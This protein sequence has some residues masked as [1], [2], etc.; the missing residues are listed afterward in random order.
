[1][2][3]TLSEVLPAS[4]VVT[5]PVELITYEVDAGLDRGAP[6][7]VVF[8]QAEQDVVRVARWATEHNVALIARG[9]GTG[10][11]GGAI[12][13]RGGVIVEF[14][15]MNRL[16]ELDVNGRS[17]VVEP[18]ILNL[19]VDDI[20]KKQGLYYP[21]DPAS[22]R[23][24]TIGG[25]VA[26]N[27]GGPHCFKYGVTTNYVTG[28]RAVLPG[29]RVVRVGG[30]A[31]DYP[32]YD[33]VGAIV[34][35]EGTLALITSIDV[36]LVQNPPGVK[37][38]MAVFDS[39]EQ[40]GQAVSAVIAAGLVPATMEMMDHH[41]AR[42]IEEYAHPGLPMDA[43]AILIIETDGYPASL[44]TQIEE[45]ADIL[46]A[47]GGRGIRIAQS[48]EERERIWFARK[49]AAGA[50]SRFA[51]AYYLVDI[52]VPRSRLAETLAEVN[53]ICERYHVHAGHV[54][55]AGDGN[56][57]PLIAIMHPEDPQQVQD[58]QNAG[59]EMVKVGVSKDGSLTGEHG[60]GTEKRQYMPMM[61]SGAELA[62]MWDI[63]Q[64]FDPRG[65]FNPGKV[66][67]SQ[68]PPVVQARNDMAV[69]RDPFTP[70]SAE[71]AAEGLAAL[72]KAGR[73]VRIGNVDNRDDHAEI[74]L[75]TSA[76]T[77]IKAYAPDD[78]YVTVGAGTLL[79]E[80]QTFLARD[81]KQIPIAS[82]RKDATIGGIVASNSN[83]PL[84]MR[85]GGI[86]D[87]VLAMTV[88]LGDGR[89]IRA[90]R[91]VVKNVAGYDMPKVFIGSYGTLGLLTDVTLKLIPQ[92]RAR[93]TLLVPVDDL[94]QGMKWAGQLLP[95]ALV[96]SGI[97]VAKSMTDA[98]YLLAYTAEGIREDVETEFERVRAVL[99]ANGAP[100]P[101]QV[102]TPTATGLWIDLLGSHADN[103]QLRIGI[104]PKDL[105]R[106]VQT[107]M[108][109]LES[110]GFLADIASGLAYAT[111]TAQEIEAS[112]VWVDALR[113][114]ALEHGGYA[115]VT[116]VP[117]AL[118]AG[119]ERWGYQPQTLD[120][121]RA[122]KARWDPA[123]ILNPGEFV[124]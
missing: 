74:R 28:L 92:P 23:A 43:D 61:Y 17:A 40:A 81:R 115:V 1:M 89:V 112:R 67:P 122:L 46:Q 41:I 8:P 85:Y 56:L 37:T 57:H 97:V 78:L 58:A 34:G 25:N 82:P 29:G 80:I 9:A 63:K 118:R 15:R 86:R 73:R 79:E 106:Y 32:E 12:A 55:H 90:G 47:H 71:Q 77:G 26:E 10:L 62:A 53:K 76:L 19:A 65:L 103:M 24:S 83:A 13:D 91:P 107:Q 68:F 51:P 99:K 102:E 66:F 33:F 64:V 22:Q 38:M 59:K 52:T 60:V 72:S 116:H 117:A 54:F 31:L 35:S 75:S 69:P 48:V 70:T 96:A 39:L 18:G 105:A 21:P 87:L 30:R 6:E 5:D 98:P 93:Q 104:P 7:G 120:L 49:S 114:P 3:K 20:V 84:R 95:L 100:S 36:R 121:M 108:T 88:A 11:S 94:A 119:L 123:G 16:L 4:Q 14:S 101:T 2:S 42:I 111:T 124:A 44:D 50:F 113:R 45:V 110:G 109:G 27:A